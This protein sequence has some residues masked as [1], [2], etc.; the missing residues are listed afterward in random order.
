MGQGRAQKQQ[1]DLK[2]VI[3]IHRSLREKKFNNKD[4]II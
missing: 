4:I 1:K 2:S 3:Y